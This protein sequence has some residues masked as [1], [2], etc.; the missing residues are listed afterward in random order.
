MDKIMQGHV[1]ELVVGGEPYIC[2]AARVD[3]GLQLFGLERMNRFTSKIVGEG[4]V[5]S[6]VVITR[7]RLIRTW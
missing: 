4:A 7:F 5:L 3:G 2:F 1:Y 6:D